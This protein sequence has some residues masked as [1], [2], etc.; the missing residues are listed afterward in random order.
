MNFKMILHTIGKILILE[1]I[2]ML[3]PLGVSLIYKENALFTFVIPI[4]LTAI[5]GFLLSL[6]K[7]DRKH[8]YAR[9]GFVVVGLSW[10]FL[11]IFGSL[12][13]FISRVIPNF[14]DAFFETVSGFTTTGSSILTGQQID[15]LYETQKGLLFWR[16]FTHW[17][18]GM[19]VLVF[20]LAILPSSEGQ[21]IFILRAE[22]TGPQVG[23]MVSKIKITARIL[24][25]IYFAFTIIE[26]IMLLCDPGITL[27][28]SLCLSMGSAGTG[29]FGI[30][31][32]SIANYSSYVQITIGVWMFLFGINFNIYFLILAG[33]IKQAL[34]SEEL[35]WYIGIVTVSTISI[36]LNLYFSTNQL[37]AA[38]K[39]HYGI[40]LKDSFFQVSSVITT[41]GYATATF[42]NWPTFSQTILFLLMFI[43]ACAGS[44]GGGI[45][46]SRI[47][48][49]FKSLKL[50][51]KKLIH[52]N[53]V[54]NIK[55][56][57]STLDENV[58]KGVK[59]YFALIMVILGV[60]T[61]IVSFDNFDFTTSLTA[62]VAT[63]N[64]IGPGLGNVVGSSGTFAYLS[65]YSKLTLIFAMLVGRLEIYPILFIFSPSTWKN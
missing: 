30:N 5:C 39:S 9:E 64:N 46:V 37:Y 21:N 29:G 15:N 8:F 48:I 45:K 42:E 43:G 52:P 62:V 47:I 35:W 18:G 41:T 60:C 12:P 27:Y 4:A 32:S 14:I 6:V 17:I 11:S 22:S 36:S 40:A 13:F 28:D 19:G 51:L 25:I 16:S 57:G 24:Y 58:V 34:K 49:L 33:K 53:C 65:W 59:S 63:L 3:L 61:L 44:T 1:A 26:V 7:I 31:S 23:K 50:E 54:S 38:Y 55:F 10:I 2:L 20:I 56:E